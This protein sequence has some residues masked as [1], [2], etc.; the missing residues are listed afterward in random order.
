[1]FDQAEALL[2]FCERLSSFQLLEA[3]HLGLRMLPHLQ[4]WLCPISLTFRGHVS[5]DSLF[6]P[7]NPLLRTLLVTLGPPRQAKI[8]PLPQGQPVSSL[9]SPGNP[10]FPVLWEAGCA[11]SPGSRWGSLRRGGG[12]CFMAPAPGAPRLCHEHL[13]SASITA[14]PQAGPHHCLLTDVCFTHLLLEGEDHASNT[15]CV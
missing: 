10:S 6:L 9:N 7:P 15:S 2:G 3:P 1:M 5:P 14:S 4:S 12:D 13:P 11:Q 8:V